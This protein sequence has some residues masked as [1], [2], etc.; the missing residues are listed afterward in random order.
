M[1]DI[2]NLAKGSKPLLEYVLEIPEKYREILGIYD[3]TFPVG[4][5]GFYPILQIQ[6]C[7]RVARFLNGAINTGFDAEFIG[8]ASAPWDG[9]GTNNGIMSKISNDITSA[10]KN[11]AV[12]ATPMVAGSPSK[13][14]S[15]VVMEEKKS[16]KV[17]KLDAL[18]WIYRA[19]NSGHEFM[20]LKD[21]ILVISKIVAA[22]EEIRCY[23]KMSFYLRIL[24][25]IINKADKAE[26]KTV[27]ENKRS[28]K[29]SIV[30]CLEKICLLL[31]SSDGIKGKSIS[32]DPMNDCTMVQMYGQYQYAKAPISRLWSKFGW[33]SLKI[34]IFKEAIALSEADFNS[35]NAILYTSAMLTK[36]YYQLSPEDIKIYS[37]SLQKMINYHRKQFKTSHTRG[38]KSL[39]NL[40]GKKHEI[41]LGIPVVRNIVILPY[42]KLNA[43]QH[44]NIM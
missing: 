33:N 18:V 25:G 23:R 26:L 9:E 41:S 16:S 10:M 24:A 42:S 21:Q 27:F 28:L 37:E 15:F 13:M 44:K 17:K 34:E 7:I 39:M 43:A 6:V 40:I 4:V 5:L 22:C 1:E 2:F 11:V 19:A 32:M 20:H 8:T 38:K 30:A 31:E 14:A 29:S 35:F 3:K 12:S 36:L